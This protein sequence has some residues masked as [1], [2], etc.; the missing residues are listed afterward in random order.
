DQQREH[1]RLLP[2]HEFMKAEIDPPIEPLVLARIDDDCYAP[3]L[4]AGETRGGT[5]V[6]SDQSACPF[7]AFATRRLGAREFTAAR[8]GLDAAARGNLVHAALEL[9]WR[10]LKDRTALLALTPDELKQRI[11]EAADQAL[12]R[13]T[14]QHRLLLKPPARRLELRCTRR[15]LERWIELERGRDE[16]RVLGLEQKILLDFAGLKLEG[17]ID[18]ID[19]TAAGAVLID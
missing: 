7:R 15:T 2:G 14:E 18:R 17:K 11:H 3:V 10:G 12:G 1:T 16:F 19:E 6:L 9:F 5:G 13:F 4:A 8:P